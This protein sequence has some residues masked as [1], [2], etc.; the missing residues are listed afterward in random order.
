MWR[1]RLTLAAVY[2][3]IILL[4]VVGVLMVRVYSFA[5]SVNLKAT[6]F[7]S[8]LPESQAGDGTFTF[9]LLGIGGGA[10]EGPTLTD[11]I[12]VVRFNMHTKVISTVG[13]PRD[14]WNPYIKDKINSVYTYA[15]QQKELTPFEYTKKKYKEFFGFPID[16][17]FLVDFN[18]FAKLIDTMGGITINL[19]KGFVDTEYPKTGAENEE[20]IPFDPNYRCRYQTLVFREGVSHLNGAVALSFVRSRHAEGDEGNDFSRSNRQ[21]IVLSAIRM[22][23]LE[24]LREHDITTLQQSAVFINTHIKRDI[25][26]AHVIALA[27]SITGA[28]TITHTLSEA[29]FEVPPYE[30]YEGRYVLIPKGEKYEYLKTHITTLL[31]FSVV[32]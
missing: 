16:Y 7:L 31:N 1:T 23:F 26:N 15:L 24:L 2:L 13:I 8:P 11:S 30:E 12:T 9:L 25:S 14:L 3:L 27:R 29:V 4:L 20:C 17:V 10:H 18:D 19:K 21:Q 6:D 32:D 22:R 5:K 28:K